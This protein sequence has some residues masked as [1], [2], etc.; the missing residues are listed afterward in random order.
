MNN[1]ISII[2]K[3]KRKVYYDFFLPIYPQKLIN[4][5]TNLRNTKNIF[6]YFDYERE[7]SGVNTAICNDDIDK[8]LLILKKVFQMF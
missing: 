7:Y 4:I 6:I 3:I 5:P 2:K 8:L 1:Q